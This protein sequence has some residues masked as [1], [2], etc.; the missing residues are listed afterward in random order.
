MHMEMVTKRKTM[1]I[2]DSDSL[3]RRLFN[4]I[5]LVEA[6]NAIV[7][8]AITASISVIH[9]PQK[10]KAQAKLKAQSGQ[11]SKFKLPPFGGYSIPHLT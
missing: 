2:F 5:W 6:G 8:K 7:M 3:R 1:R 11:R 10:L 9:A 4:A